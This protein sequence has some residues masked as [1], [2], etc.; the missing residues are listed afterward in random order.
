MERYF[1]EEIET[2]SYEE[3]RKMQSEKLVKQV[4]RVYDNVPYYR[5]KMEEKGVRPEDIKGI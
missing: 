5:K 1:Q 4:K 3:I 2:A